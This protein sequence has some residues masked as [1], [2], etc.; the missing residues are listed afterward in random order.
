MKGE[1]DTEECDQKDQQEF[2]NEE[3]E[4]RSVSSDNEKHGES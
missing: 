3:E 1:T 4:R 2:E